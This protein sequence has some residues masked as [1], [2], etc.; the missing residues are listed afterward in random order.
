MLTMLNAKTSDKFKTEHAEELQ[1]VSKVIQETSD[2][3][4]QK[5][6]SWSRGAMSDV[7]ELVGNSLRQ[8]QT[9]DAPVTAEFV[10]NL[11]DAVNQKVKFLVSAIPKPIKAF[12]N[13]MDDERMKS[14]ANAQDEQVSTLQT[15]MAI[16]KHVALNTISPEGSDTAALHDLL[17][18]PPLWLRTLSPFDDLK[19]QCSKKLQTALGGS[20]VKHVELDKVISCWSSMV[21]LTGAE[22]QDD[23]KK[24]VDEMD[25]PEEEEISKA[26][27]AAQIVAASYA[28][29]FKTQIKDPDGGDKDR[30]IN[31]RAFM[32]R[33][34]RK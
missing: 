7:L 5:V 2:T 21:K 31:L 8:I 9:C 19:L 32:W 11:A 18:K 12:T 16:F 14:L 25:L 10:D 23:I 6:E 13:L 26:E 24:F 29:Y 20:I 4:Q 30:V 28:G 34:F 22:T 3:L 1:S 17:E 15:L 33:V 27:Q